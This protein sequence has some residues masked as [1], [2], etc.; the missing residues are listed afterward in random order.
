EPGAGAAG[1]RTWRC[2]GRQF[3]D[4][5]RRVRHRR[6]AR[7]DVGRAAGGRAGVYGPVRPHRDE[8]RRLTMGSVFGLV[9]PGGSPGVTTAALALAIGWPAPVIVAECDPG[10]GAVL[11]GALGGHVPAAVGL[12]EHAIEAGR[13][14]HAAD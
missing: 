8:A 3:G 11:A 6:R 2:R 5:P 13:N 9:S 1:A 10:G 7:P 4:R 12:V 14:P